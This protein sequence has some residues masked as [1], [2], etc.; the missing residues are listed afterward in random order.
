MVLTLTYKE[1]SELIENRTG[2]IP[3]FE[4]V[5]SSTIKIIL[6]VTVMSASLNTQINIRIIKINGVLITVEYTGNR[7]V[8]FIGKAVLKRI[9]SRQSEPRLI[10]DLKSR[11]L[12][13]NMGLI[14]K[15][16][17]ILPIVN[18]DTIY[19]TPERVTVEGS[20]VK[21]KLSEI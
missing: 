14:P 5:N 11:L 9:I 12:T 13:I 18:I 7:L 10:G 6:P 3:Q 15:L 2:R 4:F 21:R 17:D 20:V 19:F 16:C 1:L 8:N